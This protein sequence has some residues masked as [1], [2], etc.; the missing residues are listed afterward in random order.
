MIT[1]K[2]GVT[3]YYHKDNSILIHRTNGSA[4]IEGNQWEWFLHG[5]YH[6][7]YGPE[8]SRGNWFIH[9]DAIKKE[10]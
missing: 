7:Y 8:D 5:K 4:R 9:G 2:Y 10:S 6:R 3:R 1:D